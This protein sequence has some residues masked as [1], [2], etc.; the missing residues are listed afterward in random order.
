MSMPVFFA[1][2]IL[3]L[4]C[5]GIYFCNDRLLHCYPVYGAENGCRFFKQM[6]V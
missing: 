1:V 3:W 6:I 2:L 4:I 5:L